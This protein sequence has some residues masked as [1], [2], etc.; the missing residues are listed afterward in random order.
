MLG[1][2][3]GAAVDAGIQLAKQ[4]IF[5]GKMNW[6]CL[7]V[8]DM[9]ISGAFSAILPGMGASAGKAVKSARAARAL[10]AQLKTA[11]STSRIAKLSNRIDAHKSEIMSQVKLQGA[12]QGG[13]TLMKGAAGCPAS[14]ECEEVGD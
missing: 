7:D 11:R 8:A 12:I 3:W 4:K 5:T 14:N 1:K 13:K 10:S 9:A 6:K 2:R